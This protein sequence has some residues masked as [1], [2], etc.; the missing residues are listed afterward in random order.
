VI[1]EALMRAIALGAA[2]APALIL[3]IYF[4]VVARARIDDELVWSSF[5]FGA[6]TAFLAMGLALGLDAICPAANGPVAVSL[7]KAFILAAGPEESCKLFAMLCIF[8]KERNSLK[9]SRI[10]LLSIGC[11]A[12]FAFLENILY[13]VGEGNWSTIASTRSISAV[14]G[15]IFNGVLMGYCL[16]RTRTSNRP[17]PWWTMALLAPVLLHG[18][19]DFFLF[20]IDERSKT[21]PEPTTM[22]LAVLV[23]DFI[24]TVIV[25]GTLA[26]AAVWHLLRARNEHG[27]APVGPREAKLLHYANTLCRHP[28]FWITTGCAC[29]L[30]AGAFLLLKETHIVF[31]GFGAFCILHALAFLGLARREAG[32]C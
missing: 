28:L 24:V 4:M 7:R 19:Y 12:G 2:T 13:V 17:F 5:G 29:L 23:T 6:C 14:P 18:T 20:V 1:P 3:L 8:W 27:H 22:Q 32:T 10:L 9:P 21:L 15:H 16:A 30:G 11:A 25:E 26:H 31:T